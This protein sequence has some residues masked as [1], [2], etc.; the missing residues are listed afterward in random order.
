MGNVFRSGLPTLCLKESGNFAKR[1]TYAV[2]DTGG[3]SWMRALCLFCL[4]L[5]NFFCKIESEFLNFRVLVGSFVMECEKNFLVLS[6]Y[7]K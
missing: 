7:K 6:I 3:A 5:Q 2:P 4:K 1:L